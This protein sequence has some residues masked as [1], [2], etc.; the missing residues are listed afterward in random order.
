LYVA[1]SHQKLWMSYPINP[2]GTLGAGGVFFNP[3]VAST[4]D[5]DGMTIDER[6]NLYLTGR[7]GIW[8]VSKYEIAVA[9]IEISEFCSNVTFGGAQGKTLFITCQDKV[10]ALDMLVR[11]GNWAQ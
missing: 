6:G 2:D 9:F 1:D 5:P 8:I 11:G 7:G 10:Y 3:N 4:R